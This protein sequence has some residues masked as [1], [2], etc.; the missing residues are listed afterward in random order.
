MQSSES[1]CGWWVHTRLAWRCRTPSDTGSLE[2]FGGWSRGGPW[3]VKSVLR[4]CWWSARPGPVCG[5]LRPSGQ[6]SQVGVAKTIT[7]TMVPVS[8]EAQVRHLFPRTLGSCCLCPATHHPLV[9]LGSRLP[10]TSSQLLLHV[11]GPPVPAG[12]SCGPFLWAL[13]RDCGLGGD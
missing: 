1:D 10:L 7:P 6:A 11:T 2:R 12:P 13:P 4:Q 8:G 9:P 5:R 3:A